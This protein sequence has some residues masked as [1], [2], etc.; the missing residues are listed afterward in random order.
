MWKRA[1]ASHVPQPTCCPVRLEPCLLKAVHI[2]RIFPIGFYWYKPFF[3]WPWKRY[4]LTQRRLQHYYSPCPVRWPSIM[5]LLRLVIW[6]GATT[7]IRRWQAL[8]LKRVG[9]R[10]ESRW[11]AAPRSQGPALPR[12]NSC[13]RN[14]HNSIWDLAEIFSNVLIVIRS[15]IKR[16][17][18]RNMYQVVHVQHED[19]KDEK[20]WHSYQSACWTTSSNTYII[21]H[22]HL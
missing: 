12:H 2:R 1:T 6:L 8:R 10:S 17:G 3:P 19:E 15:E 14:I 22:N 16:V 11:I 21:H 5:L 20:R 9:K 7:Q 4:F 18:G 13:S